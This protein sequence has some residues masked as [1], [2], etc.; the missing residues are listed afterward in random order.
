MEV[1]EGARCARVQAIEGAVKEQPPPGW[2]GQASEHAQAGCAAIR[3]AIGAVIRAS[4]TIGTPE[5]T[6]ACL[7]IALPHLLQVPGPG[8]GGR[9]PHRG[10]PSQ[11]AAALWRGGAARGQDRHWLAAGHL[12]ELV[13]QACHRYLPGTCRAPAAH[14]LTSCWAAAGPACERKSPAVASR[15][16]GGIGPDSDAPIHPDQ[17]PK[18]LTH[19]LMVLHP[20]WPGLAGAQVVA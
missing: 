7:I 16:A 2:R 1:V 19:A 18:W 10:H 17:A 3:A 4:A 9:G 5:P 11:L 15:L 14:L 20:S 6:P 12:P 8:T 13:R